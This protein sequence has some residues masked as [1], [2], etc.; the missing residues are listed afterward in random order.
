[1]FGITPAHLHLLINHLPVEGSIFS[2][3]LLLYGMARKNAE[4]I[5]T[6]FIGLILVGIFAFAADT[7]G[8][9]AARIVR[10][11]PG[12][13]RHD[14]STHAESA[15]WA[16]MVGGVTA[17]VALAGLIFAW[18]RKDEVQVVT[19]ANPESTNEYYV[20]RHKAPHTG[21]VIA[22]LI[23]ALLDVAVIART[24]YLGGKI[25]HPEIEVGF[26]VPLD[27]TSGVQPVPQ[28]DSD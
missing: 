19:S 23:L 24:A 15:D 26:T 18:R 8:D 20:R 5:R 3:L 10:K 7:T 27:T 4:L 17:I 16:K 13:D 2:T 11:I 1:M 9:G 22:C 12:T 21:F 25:R 28:K 14:I 6:A